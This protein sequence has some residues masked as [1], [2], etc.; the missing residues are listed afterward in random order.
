[1]VNTLQ[2]LDYLTRN[3]EQ[4]AEMLSADAE[5]DVIKL[6]A[7]LANMLEENQK[8]NHQELQMPAGIAGS[9]LTGA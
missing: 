7:V 1:M 4:I 5:V 9:N 2:I 3:S 6:S 8:L